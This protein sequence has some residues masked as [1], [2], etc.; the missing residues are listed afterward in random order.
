MPMNQYQKEVNEKLKSSFKR[1][2]MMVSEW[3]S[4]FGKMERISDYEHDAAL[5][6]LQNEL[7]ELW[8]IVSTYCQTFY[9]RRR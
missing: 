8:D 4:V 9:T 7:D 5:E 2:K 3:E 6:Q 1:L